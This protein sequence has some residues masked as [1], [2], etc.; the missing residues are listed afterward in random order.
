MRKSL[1][2]AYSMDSICDIRTRIREFWES[3][4]TQDDQHVTLDFNK[5]ENV[6]SEENSLETVSTTFNNSVSKQV[7]TDSPNE[8]VI[9][10]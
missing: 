5:T 9:S 6:F 4:P 7:Q 10:S 8:S 1:N 3:M 2:D